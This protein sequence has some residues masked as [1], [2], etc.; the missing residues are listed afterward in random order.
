MGDFI[1]LDGGA[2]GKMGKKARMN[3]THDRSNFLLGM[4]VVSGYGGDSSPSS[5]RGECMTR[6]GI[7]PSDL[8]TVERDGCP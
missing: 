8:V 5:L 4:R 3:M 2:G 7:A 6:R 1:K